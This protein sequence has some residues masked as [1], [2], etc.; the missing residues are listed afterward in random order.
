[1]NDN[2]WVLKEPGGSPP[3][4]HVSKEEEALHGGT[5]LYPI[6]FPVSFGFSDVFACAKADKQTFQKGEG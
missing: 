2:L 5:P 4:S 3:S 1:M 6:R